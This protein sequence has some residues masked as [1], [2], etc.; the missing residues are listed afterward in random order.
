MAVS[1]T[2]LDSAENVGLV[3]KRG[4]RLFSRDRGHTVGGGACLYV[5][6]HLWAQE[7]ATYTSQ[8][9]ELLWVTIQLS[10]VGHGL[11]VGC[12]YR[13][14]SSGVDYWHKLN[15]RRCRRGRDCVAW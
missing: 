9:I 5:K 1:E 14:P 12:N 11:L 7:V 8:D 13:P 6:S 3:D 4:Y 10:D 2:W 15:T